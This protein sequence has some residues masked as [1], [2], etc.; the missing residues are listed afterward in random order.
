MNCRLCQGQVKKFLDLGKT[1][2]PEEFRTKRELIKPVNYYPLN[3]T[4]CLNCGH[5]QL[6]YKVPV[7]NI[8]KQNY[9]YD[10]S[11]TKTG[12]KHWQKLAKSLIKRS[13]LGKKDLLIDI[14]SNTGTLLSIL[15][16]HDIKILGI[17]PSI[18][19]VKLAKK[20]GIPTINDYFTA[21]IAQKIFKKIGPA[22]VITCTNTFDHVDDLD[23]FMQGIS[24]LLRNDGVFIIEVPYFLT[25]L[26]NLTHV[27][28]HQQIDYMMLKPLIP[29]F[30]KYHLAMI[31]AEQISLH[32]GSIRMWL[33]S[34]ARPTKRL[35]QAIRQELKLYKNWPQ[36]LCE[37]A[38]KV[39][40]Q[41][42]DLA[43]VLKDVKKQGKTI[44]AIGASAKGITLL[45]YCHLGPETV[46]FITEKSSLKIGRFTASGIP[47]VSD[48]ELFSRR[49]DY[50]LLLAWNFQKEIINNLKRF[51]KN[52]GKFIVPIPK[53]EII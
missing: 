6:G 49:P 24:I 25:M 41:R 17:D 15:K 40:K 28:Y 3:L 22:K 9:Y 39:Q 8:Y 19:P 32:G 18:K 4:Y 12:F 11:V 42:D 43:T 34:N 29:F 47:V 2:L 46:D 44:A 14:G 36:I 13:K 38:K 51:Q 30:K 7:D 27:V 37:F 5:V 45:N 35:D 21:E 1:P 26:K 50:A 31:D 16:S 23:Q 10:Y 52:G 20:Q 48:H 33:S 53:I